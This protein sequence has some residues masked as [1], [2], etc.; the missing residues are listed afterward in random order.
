MAFIARERARNLAPHNARGVETLTGWDVARASA[1]CADAIRAA[2]EGD[3]HYPRVR[4][5]LAERLAA[6]AQAAK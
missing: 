6:R 5:I 3:E 1:E 2:P 4:A